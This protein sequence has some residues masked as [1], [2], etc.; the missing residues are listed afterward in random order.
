M[1]ITNAITSPPSF[2]TPMA[3][4]HVP[5]KIRAASL[6]SWGPA[7]P[8]CPT[9]RSLSP[10]PPPS[11]VFSVSHGHLSL[12]VFTPSPCACGCRRKTPVPQG[13]ESCRTALSQ[14][15]EGSSCPRLHQISERLTGRGSIPPRPLGAKGEVGVAQEPCMT[16]EK[17]ML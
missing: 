1:K 7:R 8:S 11:R 14:H 10:P 6:G 4:H 3:S 9:A 2:N 13:S 5:N 12:S 15:G 16:L 17:P